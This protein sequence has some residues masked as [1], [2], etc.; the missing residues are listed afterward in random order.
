MIRPFKEEDDAPLSAMLE[1]EGIDVHRRQHKTFDTYCVEE[2]G[3]II[4]FF[5]LREE[6]GIPSLQHFY[7]IPSRRDGKT[8]REMMRVIKRLTE[9]N[10]LIIHAVKGKEWLKK[11]IE[12]YFRASPYGETE[13]KYWYLVEVTK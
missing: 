6:W 9:G 1:S 3:E 11:L 8:S 12:G 2:K 13:D 10:R 4:G 5:T 7:V